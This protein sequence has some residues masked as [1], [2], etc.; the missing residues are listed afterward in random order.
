MSCDPSTLPNAARCWSSCIP[1]GMM[2]AVKNYLLCQAAQVAGSGG[3]GGGGV[4]GFVWDM[5]TTYT[6]GFAVW[7]GAPVGTTSAEIWTSGDGVT[8]VLSQTVAG[9]DATTTSPATLMSGNPF[10]A[11]MRFVTGGTPT[12]FTTPQ[13]FTAGAKHSDRVVVN[14][15][16]ALGVSTISAENTFV[17]S[18]ITAGLWGKFYAI[19]T[20]APDNITAVG[21]PLVK[22]AGSD[23]WINNGFGGGA[24]TVNGL[25]GDGVHFYDVGFSPQTIQGIAGAPDPASSFGIDFNTSLAT[26]SNTIEVGAEGGDVNSSIS[27]LIQFGGTCYWDCPYDGAAGRIS[28]VVPNGERLTMGN[29]SAGN[30]QQTYEY[31][32]GAFFTRVTGANNEAGKPVSASNFYWMASNRAVSKLTSDK[33]CSYVAWR[34]GFTLAEAQAYAPIV[35]QLRVDLGGGNT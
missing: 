14:G 23:P 5:D 6:K 27:I 3:G 12:A 10:Y 13:S 21:S 9:P 26:N 30:A 20:V 22:V 29:R 33:R 7:D 34:Q 11:K 15:G 17:S 35:Q 16:A 32:L 1:M 28:F 24:L 19:G 4:Q 25:Q 8:Y 18:L 31:R 2:G